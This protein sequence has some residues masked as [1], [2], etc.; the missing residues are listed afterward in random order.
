VAAGLKKPELVAAHPRNRVFSIKT[1]IGEVFS[2]ENGYQPRTPSVPLFGSGEYGVVSEQVF[3]FADASFEYVD[4]GF[5]SGV[6]DFEFAADSR[7]S[8]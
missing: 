1:P 8:E 6:D 3:E 2:R 7:L 5:F 4:L